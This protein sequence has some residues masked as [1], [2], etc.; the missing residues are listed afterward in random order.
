MSNELNSPLIVTS[1]SVRAE[2][3]EWLKATW[4][5]ARRSGDVLQ[6]AVAYATHARLGPSPKTTSIEDLLSG[7]DH[8]GSWRRTL[9]P[10]A[11][12]TI[13][14]FGLQLCRRLAD[15]LKASTGA[16]E[17]DSIL[18][19]RDDI[20]SV[21]L[22]LADADASCCIDTEVVAQDQKIALN[23]LW[24]ERARRLAV[25]DDRL[26]AASLEIDG[27]WPNLFGLA[28]QHLLDDDPR[29]LALTVQLNGYAVLDDADPR[30]SAAMS[31]LSDIASDVAL[32]AEEDPGKMDWFRQIQPLA[33][34]RYLEEGARMGLKT[35][36][37]ALE[38]VLEELES[39]RDDG[40][41]TE[42][43]RLL[44]TAVDARERA[45]R[46]SQPYFS[47]TDNG[48]SPELDSRL[49][50]QLDRFVD[51]LPVQSDVPDAIKAKR[52]WYRDVVEKKAVDLASPSWLTSL[53]AVMRER[54]ESSSESLSVE[55]ERIAAGIAH[56]LES[57]PS[58]AFG[59]TVDVA[60]DGVQAVHVFDCY[61]SVFV[62]QLGLV[63]AGN[64]KDASRRPSWLVLPNT[65][66][67]RLELGGTVIP[68][69]AVKSG[70]FI[71]PRY[72]DTLTFGADKT[73]GVIAI[74]SPSA[75]MPDPLRWILQRIRKFR[76]QDAIALAH[77]WEELLPEGE[78]DHLSGL[79]Q[80]LAPF[81]KVNDDR[82]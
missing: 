71:V 32:L 38:V 61:A 31:D 35:A 58:F 67:D 33:Y 22:L 29:T 8:F 1:G 43:A 7:R 34:W 48:V 56:H 12:S 55:G 17:L 64:M 23:R 21:Q 20:G 50:A 69:S 57:S 75:E 18:R 26:F 25:Q 2:D 36:V 80:V 72:T 30:S 37:E 16:E 51:L 10:T 74:P 41:T 70:A 62:P 5:E 81:K 6:V 54:F 52:W 47:S 49:R 27:W 53:A 63:G 28:P 45:H 82:I 59:T 3:P 4:H 76:P 42:Q 15:L 66:I 19:V 39:S 11:L 68:G 44:A 78:R 24:V 46:L 77:A 73:S 60:I 79:I 40:Q 9:S 14:E 65:S 13:R